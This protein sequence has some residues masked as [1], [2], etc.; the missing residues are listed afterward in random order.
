ML[1]KSFYHFFFQFFSHMKKEYVRPNLTK[2]GSIYHF[3]QQYPWRG[4]YIHSPYVPSK[5]FIRCIKPNL[6]KRYFEKNVFARILNCTLVRLK[7]WLRTAALVLLSILTS[8]MIWLGNNTPP[9]SANVKPII[10]LAIWQWMTLSFANTGDAVGL[11]G[12]YRR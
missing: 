12:W 3:I 4:W 8:V 2:L 1:V 6:K 10:V 7:A 5:I 9:A 11:V